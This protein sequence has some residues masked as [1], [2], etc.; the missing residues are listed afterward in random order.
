LPATDAGWGVDKTFYTTDGTAPTTNSRL[1]T[2]PFLLG[3]GRVSVRYFSIDLAGNAETSHGQRFLVEP[4]PVVVSLTFDDG[5]ESAYKLAGQLALKPHHLHGTFYVISGLTSADEL[6]M[7]WQQLAG[8]QRDGNEIGGHT[9]NHTNLKSITD[10]TVKVHEVCDDRQALLA[11]GFDPVSFA[12]PQG[13]YDAEAKAV[14][15]SCGYRTARAAGGLNVAGLGAG[16]VFAER[17]PSRDIYATRTVYDSDTSSGVLLSADR[18]EAAVTAAAT[19]GGGW[20]TFVFHQVCSQQYDPTRYA[21]CL[22][23]GYG[24]IEL[25]TLNQFLDWLQNAGHP[26]GAPPFTIVRTI[27]Q[28]ITGAT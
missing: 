25:V 21:A 26:D 20:I 13:A 4:S 8:L 10:S 6:H 27:R 12:Y 5:L 11:H 9:R 16:P 7:T 15:R 28:T 23:G 22:Q 2:G 18:M 3:A 1:Y 17:T 14:V 19:H 24:P